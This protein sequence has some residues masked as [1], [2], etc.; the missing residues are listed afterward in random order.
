MSPEAP[1]YSAHQE[2]PRRFEPI[3]LVGMAY[4]PVGMVNLPSLL[5][6]L[7]LQDLLLVPLN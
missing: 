7:R 3:A 4:T 6:L 2:Q 5:Y 1:K